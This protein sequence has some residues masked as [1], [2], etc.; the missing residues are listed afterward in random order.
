[1]K[2]WWAARIFQGKFD[3]VCTDKVLWMTRKWTPQVVNLGA[4][5]FQFSDEVYDWKFGEV[6][7][8]PTTKVFKFDKRNIRSSDKV[9]VSTKFQNPNL[10]EESLTESKKF[11]TTTF[12]LFASTK[13]YD[14]EVFS[15]R[16]KLREFE[17]EFL[18]NVSPALSKSFKSV[19]GEIFV[20]NKVWFIWIYNCDH[21][22][23]A[24][25][26]NLFGW[27]RFSLPR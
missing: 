2:S 5:I 16:K 25:R 15:R 6:F 22:N 7:Q 20:C 18:T 26:A 27:F 9:C 17:L 21:V 19:C 13:L 14:W 3:F 12:D 11:I 10:A 23:R 4:E 8:F 1:M 24:N